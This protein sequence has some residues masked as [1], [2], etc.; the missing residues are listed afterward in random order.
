MTE[1][2]DVAI[3]GGGPAGST[4]AALL[5]MK[6]RH[7]IVFE[8]EKFPRF[9]IGESLL[10]HSLRAFDRL[11]VRETMNAHYMPKFGGEIATACGSRA[12]SF[13][14]EKG[15]RST[16][17]SAYQV[18]RA[19]FDKM[20]L[21]HAT[22]A[23]AEVH[24][25]TSVEQ[26]DFDADGVTLDVRDT[27]G[28]RKVRARYLLDCSGRNAVVGQKFDL[29]LRYA[30]LQKFSVFAHYEH[31]QR[32]EG[33]EG[34]LTRLVRARNHWFWLIPL[35]ETRTSIGVVMDSADFKA[36]RKTP[37]EALAWAIDDSPLMRE[38]MRDAVPVSPVRSAGDYSYRNTRLTGD[39]WMLAGDAAGFIDPIFS[40]GVFI[41]IHSGEQC[42]DI[43][44]TVLTKPAKQ[45]GL[46]ARY[47]RKLNRLM[48]VYLR[49]VTAWY[50]DEFIDVFMNPTDKLQLAPAVNAVLAGNVGGSFAIWWRMQVFY[51]VL[52]LQRRLPLCPKATEHAPMEKRELERAA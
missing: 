33:R 34:T 37:E 47:E 9:H 22:K 50:C 13:L 49:F 20:L 11:G 6:G 25:E 23:G 4:A 51:L 28:T 17:Q 36:M 32:D 27:D 38:R 8:K 3:I 44:E 42:A 40:T 19:D 29:K 2:Y 16:V 7:V 46:F 24:E 12:L 15:F 52:F 43:L 30:H 26:L 10:P 35:D 39:R 1:P 41:A 45:P 48:D 14:F 5:A 21:D 31:V 18:E